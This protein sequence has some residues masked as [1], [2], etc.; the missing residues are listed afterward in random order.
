MLRWALIF[1]VI[2]LIAGG[3]GFTGIAGAAVG[4]AKILFCVFVGIFLVILLV[5]MLGGGPRPRDVV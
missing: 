4:V 1:L 3:L 2:A 5:A